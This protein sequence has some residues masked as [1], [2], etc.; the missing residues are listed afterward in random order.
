MR[1]PSLRLAAVTAALT[2][3]LGV[4]VIAPAAP[5]SAATV[6]MTLDIAADGHGPFT[7]SDS[8][9]GDTSASNGIVRT[10]DS[11]VYTV[12][13]NANAGTARDETFELDAPVNTSWAGIPSSCA[14]AGSSNTGAKLTC[15]L[16]DLTDQVVKVSAVLSVGNGAKNGD[17]LV[18]TGSVRAAGVP[19][20]PAAP[21]PP[22]IAS[23]APRFDLAINTVT[24]A[25]T[26]LTGPDG[27]TAGNRILYPI[28]IDWKGAATGGGLLGYERLSG[29]ISFTD[30]VSQ[31]FGAQTSP[32]VL[33]PSGA[34]AACG[35]NTGQIPGAPGGRGGGAKNVVDSG[36]ITCSQSAPGQPVKITISDVDSSLSSLPSTS[37]SGGAIIGGA[38][39]YVVS[40]YIS[41]WVPQPTTQLLTSVN[42]FR[43]LAAT[44]VSGQS[45]YPGESE[46][47]DNNSISLN[48]GLNPGGRGSTRY[49]GLAP[50][51]AQPTN[52]SGKYLAPYVTPGQTLRASTTLV[53]GGST[54]WT[55]TIVCQVID[56]SFQTVDD[57]V[58]AWAGSTG[59]LGSAPQ[60]AATTTN[61]P[62]SLQKQNCADSDLTWFSSP[63]SV[64]GG[65]SAVVAVRWKLTFPA[66]RT[67]SFS[68]S[69][70]VDDQVPNY[71]RLRVFASY[72]PGAGAKWIHDI[73][74]P[75]LANSSF[76]D[77][78]E[79]TANLARI[80]SKIVD[81]GHSAADTPDETQFVEQGSKVDFAL[82][83]SLTNATGGGLPET[84]TIRDELPVGSTYVDGSGS[85]TPSS[86][87][88]ETG[89]DKVTRQVV[90]WRL[91]NITVN[92]VLPVITFS[93][94]MDA[95]AAAQDAT[96]TAVISS[97]RDI[98]SADF[99]TAER[100]VHVVAVGGVG[101]SDTAI[102]SG[103]V[104]G[105]DLR[106]TLHY[107][108][109]ADSNFTGTDLIT[110]LAFVGDGRGTT[111]DAATLRSA[112]EAEP[113]ET[114]T[115]TSA[116][117]SSIDL[118]PDDPSNASGGSTKWC[119]QS[120]FGDSG[121]P[122]KLSEVTGVRILRTA[123]VAVGA[124]VDHTLVLSS[125]H[126]ADGGVAANSFGL[127]VS[128]LSLPVVS[129]EADVTVHSGSIGHRVW[130]DSNGDGLQESG[131]PGIAKVAV[132][133]T[134]T[135]DLGARV[136]RTTVSD[137]SGLYRFD[138]LRPGD[139]RVAFANPGG[140][141]TKQRVGSDRAIDSDVDGSGIAETT[142]AAVLQGV[143]V[144]SV[145]DD[146]A[147]DA[148][149]RR[150]VTG[151]V[152]PPEKPLVTVDP[153]TG[154]APHG[155]SI[156]AFTGSTI[157]L[158]AAGLALALVIA[159]AG[160]LLVSR[161]RRRAAE[162]DA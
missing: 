12:S 122:A 64:P 70:R 121:C 103:V 62:A 32:A 57:S 116:K 16:G 49:W 73:S 75:A 160:F 106:W 89:P 11:V 146:P 79:A 124:S 78:L 60:F 94:T 66:N 110:S 142:L 42:T 43:D 27:V 158:G 51:P 126:V 128:N 37:V 33:M 30:D 68:E 6:A 1:P 74:D 36:T 80:S 55:S 144:T 82:Y 17:R 151:V 38:K 29:D 93:V 153:P 34:D 119:S 50:S 132:R 76:S 155:P 31:M 100:S 4:S 35:I 69:L 88:T 130:L 85:L 102:R 8:S 44:S 2:G 129:N 39:N 72:Q 143:N 136:S 54:P 91:S 123:D 26:P 133:L 141:W 87:S 19:T 90:T 112:V 47:L 120:A 131:E 157:G 23:A 149:A 154:G 65:P 159:G 125:D 41:L 107:A 104:V 77:F 84:V 118:D 117:P 137:A 45:N 15:A 21:A 25:L 114:V 115:Y 113:G 92:D 40:G 48:I 83:P 22:V 109:Q 140:G 134:G 97:V 98:S 61:D 3:A 5:A 20:T 14:P 127:R 9:G 156:L 58:A 152:V 105:D 18:V 101:V 7:A 138:G 24:P 139:Y 13:V 148:G 150:S 99:R 10:N 63:D 52:I 28:L 86:I 56:R 147:V 111:T 71:S 161:R 162:T 95:R 46:P 145:S 81:P 53:N 108:N 96:N 59:G 67:I 135:D